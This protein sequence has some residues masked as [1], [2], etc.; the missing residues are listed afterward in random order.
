MATFSALGTVWALLVLIIRSID[1]SAVTAVVNGRDAAGTSLGDILEEEALDAV[2]QSHAGNILYDVD[3]QHSHA[4][5]RI[6][7]GHRRLGVQD[8]FHPVAQ[9]VVRGTGEKMWESISK[10]HGSPWCGGRP[11]V[12]FVGHQ[13][14]DSP[15]CQTSA[16]GWV[17]NSDIQLDVTDQLN[18]KDSRYIDRHVC[19][20]LDV[21]KDGFQDIICLIGAD[22]GTGRGYNE[23]YFTSED[24]SLQKVFGHG[25]DKYPTMRN[26]RIALLKG[27]MG[28]EFVFMATKGVPRSD[29]NDN[30]RNDA[31]PVRI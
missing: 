26:R 12:W 23:L 15:W 27:D 28:E 17:Q 6:R 7:R 19:T 3:G 30:V 16:G 31:D 20:T 21:D 18:A 5:A 2:A 14:G 13:R 8:R 29:G 1:W 25:L 22:S 4:D 9:L 10:P 24:G 11:T